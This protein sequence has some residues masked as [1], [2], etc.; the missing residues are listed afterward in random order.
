M[1]SNYIASMAT[2]DSVLI[3]NSQVKRVECKIVRRIL[4]YNTWMKEVVLSHYIDPKVT[5]PYRLRHDPI[6]MV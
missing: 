1:I 6:A 3:P 4:I 2:K 5:N